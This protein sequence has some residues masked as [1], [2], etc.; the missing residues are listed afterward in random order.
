M[1]NPSL[2]INAK[3]TPTIPSSL[4]YPKTLITV[5]NYHFIVFCF[6]FSQE[7]FN[8]EPPRAAL[9][10]SYVTPSD[11]FYNRNHGPI[12]IVEDINR[13]L[14]FFL[15]NLLCCALKPCG[16]KF[17]SFCDAFACLEQILRDRV[18]FGGASQTALHE[19]YMVSECV[20]V[21]NSIANCCTC[22][23]NFVIQIGFATIRV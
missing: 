8:A 17:D 10:A 5:I 13:S 7:P 15:F 19:R 3:A 21:W 14:S 22:T 6:I 23:V 11:F 18:W 16:F 9:V 20:R 2:L 12:P 4:L 1:P